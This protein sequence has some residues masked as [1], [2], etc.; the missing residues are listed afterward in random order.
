MKRNFTRRE[1]LKTLGLMIG[2]PCR[3]IV[4]MGDLK[5]FRKKNA[6]AGSIDRCIYG[7]AT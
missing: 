6:P 1:A 4:A 2:K 7:C 5:W 3:D